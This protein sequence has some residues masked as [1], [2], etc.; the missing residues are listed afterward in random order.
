MTELHPAVLVARAFLD[1]VVWGEHSR[2]WELLGPAGR[3]R[4]LAAGSRGGLDS[5]MAERIRQNTS[6]QR[7]LDDFLSGL[8]RGLRVDLSAA[9]LD[10][11][12]ASPD[13]THIGTGLVRVAL[14]APAAFHREPWAVGSIVL[15]ELDG[16]WRVDRLEP[17][18]T[19]R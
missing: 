16:D 1:A 10:Q 2:V 13:V 17:R 3:D 9:D 12:E 6:S 19:K 18:L 15:S 4:V 14:E 8:L 7:E 5:V 11:I